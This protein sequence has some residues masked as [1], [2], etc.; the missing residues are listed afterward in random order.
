VCVC[1]GGGFFVFGFF[2]VCL[3][4][5]LFV[6]FFCLLDI[7]TGKWRISSDLQNNEET[8]QRV[9]TFSYFGSILYV[10]KM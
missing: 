9:V 1:F 5:C 4:V 2:F 7:L 6:F 8:K 10:N 3:F